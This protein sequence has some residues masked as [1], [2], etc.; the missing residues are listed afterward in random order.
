M[1]GFNE[2]FPLRGCKIINKRVFIILKFL[3]TSDIHFEA[4]KLKFVR[5]HSPTSFCIAYFNFFICL[6]Y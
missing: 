3:N 1:G 6:I 4:R 2:V 5:K